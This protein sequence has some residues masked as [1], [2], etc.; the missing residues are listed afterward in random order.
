MNLQT[1][2]IKEYLTKKSI[3]FKEINGELITKCLFNG[4]DSDS[5]DN[6][7]HLYFNVETGQYQCKKCCE[8][9]NIFSLVKHFGDNLSGVVNN[10]TELN[11]GRPRKPKKF[12][13]AL[14]EKC[15]QSLPARI[16]KYLNDRGIFDSLISE[17]DLGWGE[18]YGKKWITIPIP[19]SDGKYQFFK[20]RKDPEDESH[21]TKYKFYPVGSEATIYGWEN[22]KGNKSKLV[23]CEGEF[24]QLILSKW[25]IPA[26]TSTAGAGTFKVE[27]LEHLKD[28]E[29]IYVAFDK[30]EP[31]EKE[32]EK[33][34]A[35]LTEKFPKMRLFKITLPDRMTDG[36]DITDYFEKYNGNPDEFMYELAEWKAGR[37]PLDISNFQPLTSEDLLEVLGLTIKRD[38]ANK[39]IAF[40]CQ[41]SAFTENSQF[42]VSFNAPSSTGKS[43]IPLEISGLF[44]A[45]D[46][47][48]LGNCSPNAFYHEQGKY[49][50]LTNTITVDLS[51]KIIIFT[52]QPSTLLLE[53]IRSLLSHDEKE[54]Q[55]KITDKSSRGGNKTKTVV[56]RGFP[57]VT[58]CSAGLKIDEQ[59]GTRF[60]LLSPEIS[61]EKMREA[62]LEKIK[63]ETDNDN[64]R[65]TLEGNPARMQLKERIEAIRDE[66]ISDVIIPNQEII[67]KTFLEKRKI[68]KPRHQRDIGRLI[69]IV[70]IFCLLNL[71]FRER[72]DDNLVATQKDIDEAI[73]VWEEIAESQDY[74]LSPYIYNLFRDVII[75]AWETKEEKDPEGNKL[76]LSRRE[77]TKKYYEIYG[78]PLP[79]WLLR[80][81]I[82]PMLESAGL[83][84]Q[85]KNDPKDSRKYLIYPTI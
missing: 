8:R 26:I 9:G 61:Q 29:N 4:C 6:E 25:A 57:S 62:I 58:F 41:L 11:D 67:E 24:D 56:I 38:A 63:K 12:N 54:L 85:E 1:I 40:L 32:G 10:S 79:D 75:P 77:I 14:V 83:I 69:A 73:A 84:S 45:N 65:K 15:H 18:F 36:K 33:L 5:R 27:W 60:I 66:Q 76:G 35:T 21:K 23:I 30:D 72:R 7:G 13:P 64:Y 51:R 17:Y 31:G 3:E 59:E 42:N 28:F 53:K 55:S 82:L 20:L 71:W 46:L 22:L 39:L 47:I 19:N 70:K 49:N 37:K 48:K 50:K 74:G 43:F 44:P 68:L 81:Q 2:T 34:I 52:D 78:R 16:R 80:Q